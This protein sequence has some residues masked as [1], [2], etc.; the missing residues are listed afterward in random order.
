VH[1]S[2]TTKFVFN[3]FARN[4]WP[5]EFTE[6]DT[7][8]GHHETLPSVDW[9]NYHRGDHFYE[10]VATHVHLD[11]GVIA[12][13]SG[14]SMSKAFVVSAFGLEDHNSVSSVSTAS[15]NR[16]FQHGQVFD[17]PGPHGVTLYADYAA[18]EDFLSH[19]LV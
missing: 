2:E 18:F 13:L 3:P 19:L 5:G 10:Y 15:F 1:S 6:T 12:L 14:P 16:D 17:Y 8:M 11:S 7:Q 4:S 9:L